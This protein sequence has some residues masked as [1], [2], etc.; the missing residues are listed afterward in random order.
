MKLINAAEALKKTEEYV[1]S[2]QQ[3]LENINNQI[4][5]GASQGSTAVLLAQNDF[6]KRGWNTVTTKV[7]ERLRELGYHITMSQRNNWMN[8]SWRKGGK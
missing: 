2:Y 3:C 1:D 7:A 8:I 6:S 5:E 4:Q